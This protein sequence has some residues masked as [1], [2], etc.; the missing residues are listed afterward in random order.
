MRFRLTGQHLPITK[1]A[2]KCVGVNQTCV[3]TRV[4][5]LS[6]TLPAPRPPSPG[7]K[8]CGNFD[9]QRWIRH[10]APRAVRIYHPCRRSVVWGVGV[11]K[12][13]MRESPQVR[14][15]QSA[16]LLQEELRPPLRTDFSLSA[17]GVSEP[18]R[19]GCLSCVSVS[20]H[21]MAAAQIGGGAREAVGQPLACVGGAAPACVKD[22]SVALAA[23][24]TLVVEITEV[25]RTL[26][27]K[28]VPG[29]PP[30]NSVCDGQTCTVGTGRVGGRTKKR[31]EV[32][33]GGRCLPVA[34]GGPEWRRLGLHSV[35]SAKPPPGPLRCHGVGV[36]QRPLPR[37]RIERRNSIEYVLRRSG[38]LTCGQ[39]LFEVG[40]RAAGE[41]PRRRRVGRAGRTIAVPPAPNLVQVASRSMERPATLIIGFPAPLSHIGNTASCA[42]SGAVGADVRTTFLAILSP[43]SG[44]LLGDPRAPVGCWAL[45]MRQNE[46]GARGRCGHGPFGLGLGPNFVILAHKSAIGSRLPPPAPKPH[47]EPGAYGV[48]TRAL[49]GSVRVVI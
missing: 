26:S 15:G 17:C 33:R 11:K 27:G 21:M 45:E 40:R 30:S 39:C 7:A 47:V 29:V 41:R 10:A 19:V 1:H 43:H 2:R 24:R 16:P 20:Q 37:R 35:L 14:S 12:D 5:T 38:S 34:P 22:I 48:S 9:E 31:A 46:G 42:R 8:Y 44:P 28:D 4:E 32:A 36:E 49:N 13:A 25:Q 3:A 23:E 6:A 18:S